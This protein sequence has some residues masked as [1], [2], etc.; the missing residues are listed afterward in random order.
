M[1]TKT[2]SEISRA[3]QNLRPDWRADA[4]QEAELA[5]IEHRNPLTAIR[6]FARHETIHEQ[7]EIPMSQL[8]RLPKRQ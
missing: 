3:V 5:I 2:A 4:I 8:V 7:R 6:N 1:P